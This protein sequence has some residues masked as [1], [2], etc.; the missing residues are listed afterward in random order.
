MAGRIVLFGATG[1]TGRLA[2]AELVARGARP[3]LAAR[4]QDKLDELSRDLGGG[5]ETAV[6]DVGRPATVRALVESGDALLSTVGRFARWGDPA[7]EAAIDAGAHYVDSTGEP[8]WIRRVFDV[9]GPKAERAGAALLP[10]AGYDYVPGN[11]AGALALRDA[12][13]G[14]TGVR[15]GYFMSGGSAGDLR[16]AMSGG[17]A[18]SL[19]G[20]LIEPSYAWR[21]G[22]IQSERGARSVRTLPVGDKDRS[23]VTVG[24]SEHFTLPRSYPDLLDVEVCLGWF[25]PA[26]RVMQAGSLGTDLITRVPGARGALD[27]AIGRFVKGSTGGP[28]AEARS[29]SGSHVVGI[30][31]GPDGEHLGEAHVTGINGYTFTGAFLA[32]AAIEA[33]AGRIKGAG[34]VGPVDAFGLERLQAGCSD[35]GLSPDPA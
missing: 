34:A 4:S 3:V 30:A 6:A 5:F 18:A 19:A 17:T 16:G 7:A 26:S 8:A 15:V 25:G 27:K 9:H 1:Y 11:L 22:R 33:A 2:A 14:A 13:D 12:G 21:G 29:R 20:T 35:C 24:G 10:A 32:W 31:L 28:D 23:A